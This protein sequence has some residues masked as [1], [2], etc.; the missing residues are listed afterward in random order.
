MTGA[1]F[2]KGT[3]FL[4]FFVKKKMKQTI[5]TLATTTNPMICVTLGASGGCTIGEGAGIGF[6]FS[7]VLDDNDTGFGSEDTCNGDLDGTL[8]VTLE[9][10]LDGSIDGCA[11]RTLDGGVVGEIDNTLEGAFVGAIVCVSSG[12]EKMLSN[13]LP[14]PNCKDSVVVAPQMIHR[15]TICTACRFIFFIFCLLESFV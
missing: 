9:G 7:C 8:Y 10:T 14:R 3:S 4:L 13:T 2:D 5:K 15:N 12:R 6:V 11:D 1:E